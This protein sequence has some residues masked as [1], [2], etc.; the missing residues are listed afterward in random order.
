MYSKY[1]KSNHNFPRTNFPKEIMGFPDVPVPDQEESY[2]PSEDV[3]AF[4][5]SYAVKFQINDHIK[6]EHYVIRIKP[7]GDSAWE[8]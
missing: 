4:L 8:V 5:N 6:F 3:V 2:I 7:K 1:F